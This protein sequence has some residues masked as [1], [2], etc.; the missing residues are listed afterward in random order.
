MLVVMAF[1]KVT[2][3][4]V[5]LS[6]TKYE[7]KGVSESIDS[8]NKNFSSVKPQQ[9][10]QLFFNQNILF[11]KCTKKDQT[12]IS[13]ILTLFEY[14]LRMKIN[15]KCEYEDDLDLFL[16]RPNFKRNGIIIP[17]LLIKTIFF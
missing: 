6:L 4:K 5:Y 11:R 1:S 16:N 7:H 15:N 17:T 14:I 3:Q 2:H 12:N 10:F 13:D 8:D 9:I